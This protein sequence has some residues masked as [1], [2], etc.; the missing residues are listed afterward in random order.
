MALGFKDGIVTSVYGRR[1]G[2]QTLSTS[3]TG[4]SA[5]N[6]PGSFI[7]GPDALR[8]E[9]VTE[10]TAKRVKAFG[11]SLLTTQATSLNLFTIDPPVTGQV[12]WVYF[13]TTETSVD[14]QLC[15]S[16][17]PTVFRTS[18]SS[19]N[20]KLNSSQGIP[21]WVGLIGVSTNIWGVIGSLST[22]T[23]NST[24]TT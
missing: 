7:V 11:Y 6:S 22:G 17:S 5:Q 16:G 13:A 4:A 8:A 23:I 9:T 24:Q 20:T 2:L 12:K 3:V 19:T 10:T 15:T 21:L 1:L 14:L 18:A